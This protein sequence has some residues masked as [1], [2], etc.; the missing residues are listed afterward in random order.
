MES[1]EEIVK[2]KETVLGVRIDDQVIMINVKM[3]AIELADAGA[4][5][6]LVGGCKVFWSG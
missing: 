1:V 2:A 4:W 5:I 6:E 3:G